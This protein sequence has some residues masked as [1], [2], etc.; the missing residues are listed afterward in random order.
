MVWIQ[1]DLKAHP[2]PTPA[3]DK[4]SLHQ[5]RLRRALSS[6]DL[7]ICRDGARTASLGN[8]PRH[9]I[10]SDNAGLKLFIPL[11]LSI[12]HV[13]KFLPRPMGIP[14][15]HTDHLLFSA[16]KVSIICRHMHMC[17]QHW[18]PERYP[19]K[20]ELHPV[21]PSHEE[22]VQHIWAIRPSSSK[23]HKQSLN[24]KYMISPTDKMLTHFLY[25]VGLGEERSD[26]STSMYTWISRQN[27]IFIVFCHR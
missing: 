20:S 11:F 2:V 10:L 22:L 4:A 23:A 17:K 16:P 3:M 26:L 27:S 14:A 7:S 15:Q 21:D 18:E 12:V 1:R 5:I 19:E 9:W 25:V 6:L 24:F 8:L 13:E